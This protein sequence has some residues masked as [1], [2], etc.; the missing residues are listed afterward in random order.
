MSFITDWALNQSAE[1]RKALPG[2]DK[3]GNSQYAGPSAVQCRFT[4]GRQTVRDLMG[5]AVHADFSMLADEEVE[6]G[7]LV[8]YGGITYK[9]TGYSE[10]HWVGGEYIGRF[11]FG[12]RLEAGI[13]D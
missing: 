7:D 2:R 11:S 6:A 8:I 10:P 1:W 3:W 13:D 4:P 5:N 9:V 12:E